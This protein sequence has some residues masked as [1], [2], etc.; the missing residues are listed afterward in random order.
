MTRYNPILEAK[1][2]IKLTVQFKWEPFQYTVQQ[3]ENEILGLSILECTSY[4]QSK[5]GGVSEFIIQVYW[6]ILR[7]F[8]NFRGAFCEMPHPRSDC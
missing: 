3:C 4:I 1:H 5:E 7:C 8:I 6:P 2:H